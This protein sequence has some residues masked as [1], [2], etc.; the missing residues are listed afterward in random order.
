[1]PFQVCFPAGQ[2]GFPQLAIDF[3]Q[4]DRLFDIEVGLRHFRRLEV[5][6]P[7]EGRGQFPELGETGFVIQDLGIGRL[8]LSREAAASSFSMTKTVSA[9]VRASASP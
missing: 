7:V 8:T 6:L 9:A 3:P 2:R 4:E 1:M 5:C